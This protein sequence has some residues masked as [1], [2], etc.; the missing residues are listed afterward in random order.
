M[1]VYACAIASTH[2]SGRLS[3][4][5]TGYYCLDQ[6]QDEEESFCAEEEDE[7]ISDEVSSDEEVEFSK[8]DFGE[9]SLIRRYL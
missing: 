6:S 5:L 4:H 8:E 2:Y 1:T 3:V 7:L 9:V